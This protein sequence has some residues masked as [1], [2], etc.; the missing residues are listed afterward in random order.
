MR[1]WFHVI[2][3]AF[4]ALMLMT[5]LPAAAQE[6]APA[7]PAPA[8]ETG[9]AVKRPV[10][11]A[12]CATCPWG[13]V[14]DVIKAAMEPRGWDVLVC[15]NCSGQNSTRIVSGAQRPQPLREGV[16]DRPPPPDG[17][18]DFGV[19][20]V[21]RLLWAYE[22][23]FDY[24]A[25]EPMR[26]LRLITFLEH[27]MYTAV[28]VRKESGITDLRQI[29]ERRMPV[30]IS[31]DDNPYVQPILDYYGLTRENVESWGGSFVT[32]AGVAERGRIDFDVLIHN[33][34]YLSNTPES[35]IW[36]QNT[37][38]FDLHF[39]QLPEDL[40]AKMAADLRLERVTIPPNILRGVD[41]P[42]ESVGR[43]GQVVYGRD[44]M[45]EEFAY[46]LA[47]AMDEDSRRFIWSPL[48]VVH[49]NTSTACRA[50]GLPLHP[51]AAR[52]CR[53]KGYPQ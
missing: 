2:S 37:Q 28:A 31:A 1:A 16:T 7:A 26:N 45:P 5:A 48:P 3:A 29:A 25:E 51:G 53:E 4:A 46:E 47:K 44:D 42:I 35:N 41:R 43:S 23:I 17:P 30:R 33:Q 19:T 36:Y 50:L 38:R 8:E 13:A 32:G 22:G 39:L 34:F 18:V 15:Y 10:I 12:A 11:G 6:T 9:F 21:H 27:P 24:S 52:Y 40:L 20:N 14:A 49:Y